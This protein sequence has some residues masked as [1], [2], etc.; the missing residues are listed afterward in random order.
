MPAGRADAVALRGLLRVHGTVGG[1]V[2][3]GA[4]GRRVDGFGPGV[5]V[6]ERGDVVVA[7]G[8]EAGLFGAEGG[9]R[10]GFACRG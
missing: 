6:E 5:E 8:P 3:A 4:D 7:A 9:G 10:R 2:G 1:A